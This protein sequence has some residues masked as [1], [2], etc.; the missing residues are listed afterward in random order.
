MQLF[1]NSSVYRGG[2]ESLDEE[3]VVGDNLKYCVIG[4]GETGNC[5]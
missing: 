4:E 3:S 5:L 2:K 1:N